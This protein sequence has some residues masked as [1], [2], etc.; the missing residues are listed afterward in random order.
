MPGLAEVPATTTQPKRRLETEF[1]I[2]NG[3]ECTRL[4]AASPIINANQSKGDEI[5]LSWDL[6]VM[7]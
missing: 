1:E 2:E 5:N 6:D 4:A 3:A 7:D